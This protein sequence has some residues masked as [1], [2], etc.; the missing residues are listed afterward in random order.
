MGEHEAEPEAVVTAVGRA[1]DA[2]RRA[3]VPRAAATTT[4]A[5][6]AVR[7]TAGTCRIRLRGTA[8]TAISILAP[9][10]HIARHIVK[11]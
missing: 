8:V 2:K 3:A 10:P 1:D 6:H 7:A 9:L 4:A 11:T 5:E